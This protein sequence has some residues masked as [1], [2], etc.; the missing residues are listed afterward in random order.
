M[1]VSGHKWVRESV[2]LGG[3]RMAGEALLEKKQNNF[4]DSL[5]KIVAYKA[6]YMF[7]GNEPILIFCSAETR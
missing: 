6:L 7:I 1:H 2:L 5:S 4:S 3:Y